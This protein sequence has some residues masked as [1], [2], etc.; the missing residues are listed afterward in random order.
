RRR[1]RARDHAGA[2]G[3]RYDALS[4]SDGRTG[5]GLAAGRRPGLS[6]RETCGKVRTLSAGMRTA[7]PSPCAARLLRALHLFHLPA[8]GELHVRL[9][10]LDCMLG[11]ELPAGGGDVLAPRRADRRGDAAIL[12]DSLE[13]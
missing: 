11:P 6:S 7:G 5:E 13:A 4:G 9:G 3:S 12:Q 8:P 2:H 10:R 1:T